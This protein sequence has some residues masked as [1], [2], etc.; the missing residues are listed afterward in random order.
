MTPFMVLGIEVEAIVR[1]VMLE[2]TIDGV[3]DRNWCVS[4][5][6][7]DERVAALIYEAFWT[8]EEL[9]TIR[10]RSPRDIYNGLEIIRLMLRNGGG[11]S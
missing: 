7:L 8:Q 9:F 6:S 11:V 1:A 2:R 3:V 5:A 10:A 4:C